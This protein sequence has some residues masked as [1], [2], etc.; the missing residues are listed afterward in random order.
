MTNTNP[1][2]AIAGASGATT[3]GPQHGDER[4]REVFQGFVAGTFYQQ[5]LKALRQ[6]HGRPAYLHGGRAE[7]IFQ[8]R[9]DQHVAEDLAANSGRAFSDELFD[10][11]ARRL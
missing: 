1:T 6:T 7:E 10:A 5:M 2:S 8:A 4:L 11:F 9:L 3:L